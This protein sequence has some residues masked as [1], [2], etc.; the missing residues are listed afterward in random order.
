[1]SNITLPAPGTPVAT[2]P[3]PL[4]E[5]GFRATLRAFLEPRFPGVTLGDD[6]DIFS[7]GFVNSLF[8]M[9]LVLFIERSIGGQIPNEELVLD[10]FRSIDAMTTLT[11]RIHSRTGAEA[12]S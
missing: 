3:D 1:M 9:E 5:S 8:A 10:H 11:G 4:S 2:P 6:Q 7:L 12:T